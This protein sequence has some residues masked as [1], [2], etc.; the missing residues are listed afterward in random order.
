MGRPT[1]YKKEYCELV[2]KHLSEGLSFES[3]AAITDT[4]V[5]TMYEWTKAHKDFSDAKKRGTAKSM[6]FWEKRLLES[7][8]N[9]D[10][11]TTSIIYTM[12]CR[13]G[14]DW[15]NGKKDRFKF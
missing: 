15:L 11:N 5:D 7:V 8:T 1:K 14:G 13:F 6:L 9:P 2:V 12:K 10:L 4:C 3:F